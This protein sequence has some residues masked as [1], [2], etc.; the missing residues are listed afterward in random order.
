MCKCICAL[1]LI[2]VFVAR[3]SKTV[4]LGSD[5]AEIVLFL[6]LFLLFVVVVVV[7]LAVVVAVAAVLS[8]TFVWLAWPGPG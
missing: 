2:S 1:P 4:C 5:Q 6:L 7:T 3:S 8:L